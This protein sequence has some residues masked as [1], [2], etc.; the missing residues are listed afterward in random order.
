MRVSRG[1]ASLA[2]VVVAALTVAPARADWPHW[3]GAGGNGVS[4][5]ATPPVECGADRTLRWKVAIP[6]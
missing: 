5:T 6:G 3:R 4:L 1:R 2:V